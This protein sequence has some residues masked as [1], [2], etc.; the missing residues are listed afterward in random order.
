MIKKYH[1]LP[2]DRQAN[3]NKTSSTVQYKVQYTNATYIMFEYTN[4]RCLSAPTIAAV[5][6]IYYVVYSSR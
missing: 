3:F 1:P 4:T 5:G 2:Q 6:T